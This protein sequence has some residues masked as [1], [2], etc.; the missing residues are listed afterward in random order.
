MKKTKKIN[1]NPYFFINY[2]GQL[3]T[4]LFNFVYNE[5]IILNF[6]G[7]GNNIHYEIARRV[8][9]IELYFLNN[10]NNNDNQ[11]ENSENS[12]SEDFEIVY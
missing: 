10:I 1:K 4:A 6:C 5:F 12:F 11:S 8:S 3:I 2:I 7:L 9:N